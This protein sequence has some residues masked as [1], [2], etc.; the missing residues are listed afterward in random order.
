MSLSREYSFWGSLSPL[1]GL[2]GAA[3]LVMASARF[4]WAIIIAGSLFWVYSLTAFTYSFMVSALNKKFF[5]DTGRSYVFICLASFFGS[6][7]ILLFWLIC[8]LAAFEALLPMLLVPLFCAG[9]GIFERFASGGNTGDVFDHV[10]DAASQ[11]AMLAVLTILFSIVREPLSYCS[12][13]LPGSADGLVPI[14]F[15]RSGSFFP[16]GIFASSAGALLL[17]GYII[18]IYQYSKNSISGRH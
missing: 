16:I 3:L 9:S 7:Y 13:S 15:F 18:C 10:S 6:I 2:S 8:P 12:L 1:G 4:S 11:A 14:M 5:P 17:L